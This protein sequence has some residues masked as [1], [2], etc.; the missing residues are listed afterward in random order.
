M[1]R[2][3]MATSGK[4][5]M[6]KPSSEAHGMEIA[7]IFM[8][9]AVVIAWGAC[10]AL[11]ARGADAGPAPE[12]EPV[13]QAAGADA[14][15]AV[16]L[17]TTDGALEAALARGGRILVHGLAL[18]DEAA[19]KAREHVTVNKLYGLA[20]VEKRDRLDALPYA[21]RIANW[22][23][24]ADL[25]AAE[26]AGLTWPEL[27]RVTAP[28]G[29]VWIGGSAAEAVRERIAAHPL[30]GRVE[31]CDP[32]GAWVRLRVSRSWGHEWT[33]NRF[34]DAGM[35]DLALDPIDPAVQRLWPQW[36]DGEKDP[37]G[38]HASMSAILCAGGRLV[39]LSCIETGAYV[40]DGQIWRTSTGPL[41]RDGADGWRPTGR[42]SNVLSCRDAYNGVVKWLRPWNGTHE[43][44]GKRALAMEGSRVYT[45]EAGRLTATDLR[46]GA[47]LYAADAPV[48][49]AEDAWLYCDA[50]GVAVHDP[51]PG[52]L[53]VFEAAS[54]QS[55]WHLKE[56]VA[57]AALD[58]GRLIVAVASAADTAD[59]PAHE[60]RAF[61]F[62]TGNPL[63]SAA[64]AALGAKDGKLALHKAGHQCVLVTAGD[65]TLVL[66]AD[67][68]RVLHRLAARGEPWFVGDAIMVGGQGRYFDRATGRPL[69]VNVHRAASGLGN[70]ACARGAFTERMFWDP[71]RAAPAGGPKKPKESGAHPF[72]GGMP[73]DK[74]CI[75]GAVVA[76]GTVY[77]PPQG[78]GCAYSLGITKGLMAL[79]PAD[80]MPPAE[81]FAEPGPLESGPAL[82]QTKDARAQ[83]GDWPMFRKDGRRSAAGE[84]K[85]PDD[86]KT[87]WRR[88]LAEKP[89]GWIARTAW[90]AQH[91]HNHVIS[92]PVVANGRVYVALVDAHQVAALDA[93]SGEVV[94]RYTA[95][96]R[97]DSPPTIHRGLC[98]FG[99]RDG[100]VQCLRAED[101]QLVW[102]RR[103][104]PME[105]RIVVY[106]QFESRYPAIGS[107]LVEGDRGY[108]TAGH[109]RQLGIMVWEFEPATGKTL[110]YRQLPRGN[111]NNDVLVRGDDGGIYLGQV[112]VKASAAPAPAGEAKPAA[113]KY[114]KQNESIPEHIHNIDV[115]LLST[116]S[117]TAL[118]SRG[119]LRLHRVSGERWAWSGDRMVA[120]AL[121]SGPASSPDRPGYSHV[122]EKAPALTC[123][124]PAKLD[125]EKGGAMIWQT[126]V[127]AVWALALSENRVVAAGPRPK[128]L[129]PPEPVWVSKAAGEK[130][131][132]NPPLQPLPAGKPAEALW[133]AAMLPT[134]QARWM[135]VRQD[136]LSAVGVL[137]L[138]DL[139]DGKIVAEVQL[140]S[141][142]VQDGLA[143]AGGRVYVATADG[144]VVCL[145]ARE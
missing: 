37:L 35:R 114:R 19:A 64:G 25:Q 145:G 13:V 43:K 49:F 90:R 20:S 96:A 46:D 24:V 9:A 120:F 122:L 51:K 61:D 141:T 36:I 34:H 80:P 53:Y 134:M 16:V 79:V 95:N 74:T 66:A 143:V 125:G 50:R 30:G 48:R 60:V 63:W 21:S 71:S 105:Q 84:G 83:P 94:W 28:G 113:P 55:K 104:A 3:F 135:V 106:G 88:P 89:E 15:V 126:P 132:P 111:F 101:G 47:V 57:S 62:I 68:G 31:A 119:V 91:H 131:P 39:T 73:V 2:L 17:G 86:L 97:I 92:A 40:R 11:A 99:G 130:P 81:A 138:L 22:V 142:P 127:E 118:I 29:G 1:I 14:G 54:G 121:R 116:A 107:V 75:T 44:K 139:R 140:P 109:S 38:S 77:S 33:H 129:P 93:R 67:Q 124:D 137:H 76:H 41:V 65:E 5:D 110:E 136:P 32:A 18:S 78:C 82:G 72:L 6:K 45:V 56:G 27:I 8:R 7:T 42:L 59:K 100:W 133:E 103:I 85:L 102:R 108:A 70:W 112:P 123:A 52:G 26:K 4:P 87:L 69:S 12:P 98:L 58:E 115:S 10:F 128:S 144:C 23:V 117:T